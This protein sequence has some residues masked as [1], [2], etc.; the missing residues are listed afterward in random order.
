M[1]VSCRVTMGRFC[2]VVAFLLS[3][4]T[5]V[6]PA[7]VICGGCSAFPV[8]APGV[9]ADACVSWIIN[10]TRADTG[11]C[12]LNPAPKCLPSRNCLFSVSIGVLD[13]CGGT[14]ASQF[15]TDFVD[16]AG[17]PQH[18][19][20]CGGLQPLNPNTGP[21]D[22][23]DLPIACGTMYLLKLFRMVGGVWVNFL[24]V[25]ARCSGCNPNVQGG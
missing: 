3:R 20:L 18:A 11:N 17:T 15:C 22:I 9:T 2:V 21:I 12:T 19:E 7:Q 16:A 8:G 13:A 4:L 14:F 1:G 6:A 24:T 5:S 10:W 25:E 23:S